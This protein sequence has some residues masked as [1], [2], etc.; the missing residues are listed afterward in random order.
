MSIT[1]HVNPKAK[2][3]GTY[4]HFVVNIVRENSELVNL[5]PFV[6]TG[7]A[8]CLIGLMEYWL[9]FSM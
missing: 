2:H 8:L 7:V 6:V 1:S 5:F 3:F 9:H 4:I